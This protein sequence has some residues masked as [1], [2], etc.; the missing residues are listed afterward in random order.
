MAELL[1]AMQVDSGGPTSNM[2]ERVGGGSNNGESSYEGSDVE[3][4]DETCDE[5]SAT[6]YPKLSFR[7]RA[8]LTTATETDEVAFGNGDI[9]KYSITM[10]PT[11]PEKF[12]EVCR[13]VIGT[14]MVFCTKRACNTK[15]KGSLFKIR[16]GAVYVVKESGRIGHCTPILNPDSVSND[17]MGSLMSE[18]KTLTDWSTIFGRIS[19]IKSS[20]HISSVSKEDLDNEAAEEKAA[21]S[22]KNPRKKSRNF[23]DTLSD[24]SIWYKRQKLFDIS[25]LSEGDKIA[26]ILTFIQNMDL[27]LDSVQTLAIQLKND[28]IKNSEELSSSQIM[29]DRKITIMGRE[30]GLK[31]ERL[32]SILETPSIWQ[33]IEQLTN[34]VYSSSLSHSSPALTQRSP[35]LDA[36]TRRI[37]DLEEK[38]NSAS[39]SLFSVPTTNISSP[40]FASMRDLISVMGKKVL[41]LEKGES[42][43]GIRYGG[44]SFER[45]EDVRAWIHVNMDLSDVGYIVDPHTVMEHVYANLV[46]ED[47]L[48]TFQKL[49]KLEIETLS[50]GLMMTSYQQPVPKLFSTGKIK[51]VKEDSSFLDRIISWDDWDYPDTGMR[52]VL[53]SELD[54]FS[55]SHQRIVDSTLQ[56][57]SPAH[58]LAILSATESVA[59]LES[60]MTFVDGFMKHLTKARFS[61][62]KA[63]HVTSRLVKRIFEEV[64]QPR[65]GVIKAFKT[66][67]M[68]Q[69]T[70]S[71]LWSNLQ[72]L[73]VALKLKSTGLKDLEIVSSE[74]VKFLLVNTGYDSIERLTKQVATLENVASESQKLAK[75]VSS[76]LKTATNKVDEMKKTIVAF[77]KRLQKLEK[78]E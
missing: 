9:R 71:V 64:F 33:A 14:G 23:T 21:M 63:L 67:D 62:K 25:K 66:R 1:T 78:K 31:S 40:E 51:V 12:S 77:E 13:T 41:K 43:D 68:L 22:F 73:Q 54:A 35:S 74:L 18:S 27:G 11:D 47:F 76:S 3:M 7:A 29:M 75:D 6:T 37:N 28:I 34:K 36:V 45:P 53:S 30:I 72:S 5:R 19:E 65:Q 38:L 52:A 46:G 58:T 15:H 20:G 59:W 49:H 24:D 61:H 70:S 56:D 16:P 55:E 17:C 26:S 4:D 8:K 42:I 44:V 48:S 60:L 2:E 39:R 57:G 69:V 50:Q 32:N 10:I